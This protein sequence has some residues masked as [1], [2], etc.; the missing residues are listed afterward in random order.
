MTL[1]ATSRIGLAVAA[2]AVLG[3]AAC[4]DGETWTNNIDEATLPTPAVESLFPACPVVDP[5]DAK[6]MKDFLSNIRANQGKSVLNEDARF[7]LAAQSHACDMAAHGTLQVSGTNGSNVVNRLKAAEVGNC[8]Q[9]SQIIGRAG[10]ASAQAEGWMRDEPNRD[11]IQ[12]QGL[13]KIGVGMARGPNGRIWW[14]VVL[15]SGC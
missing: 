12:Q 2:L 9:A 3:L 8:T 14:S 6:V 11:T 10:S 15:G 1:S 13:D 5:T 4:E 7:T